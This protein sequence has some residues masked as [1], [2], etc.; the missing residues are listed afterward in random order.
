MS[1]DCTDCPY[2]LR[3]RVTRV[4]STDSDNL[5]SGSSNFDTVSSDSEAYTSLSELFRQEV[6]SLT[7][8]SDTINMAIAMTPEQLQALIEGIKGALTPQVVQPVAAT[9]SENLQPL[10]GNF[11][12]CHSRFSGAKSEDIDAFIDAITV[13][14]N[15]INVSDENALKGLPML[16][17][18]LAATWWQGVKTTI[19]DWEEAL[20]S[21]RRAF[22]KSKPAHKIFR[23]LFSKPQ[24]EKE[25]TDI[26]VSSARALL[27]RL[28][29]VPKL[30]ETH[31]LDMIYGLLSS[32]IRHRVSRDE[33]TSF[34][35]LIQRARSIE[36]NF[37]EANAEVT[38]KPAHN[39]TT[40]PQ[41]KLRP[42]CDFCRNFGH[43]QDECRKFVRTKQAS[44]SSTARGGSAEVGDEYTANSDNEKQ[45]KC[46]GCG[47]PGFIRS[48]CPKCSKTQKRS[49]TTEPNSSLSASLV[50]LLFMDSQLTS[51][52][53][54]SRPMLKIQV[55]GLT[56]LAHLDTGA[57]YNIAGNRLIQQVFYQNHPYT[58][59]SYN[60]ILADGVKRE[61]NA[62]KFTT[63][64]TLQ[65][66]SFETQFIGVPAHIHSKTLLG[67]EFITSAGLALDFSRNCWSFRDSPESM[68]EFELEPPHQAPKLT[69]V[70]SAIHL[71][72][73][74]ATS[75]TDLDRKRLNA[76]LDQ[77]SDLFAESGP[78]TTQ[79][80][81]TIKLTDDKPVAVPPYRLPPAK[82]ALLKEELEKLITQDIIEECDSP[83]AAPVVMVPKKD[84]GIRICIDYRQLN[85][86]TVPD[87]YPLPRIDDLLHSTK[88]AKIFTT[89]DL[90]SGYYQVPV[91]TEDRDKTAFITPFGIYRFKRLPF[92]LRNAP[93]T[94][95]RMID[96][97]K[98]G[99]PGVSMLAYLDDLIVYSDTYDDHI[100]DLNKVFKRLR[101]FRL[102]INRS[103][104]TF[105]GT[106]VKYLGHIINAE[107]IQPDSDKVAAI[108]KM[109]EPKNVKEL[110]SFVQT[111]SWFRRFIPN[112]ANVA[113][114]LTNLTKKD[115]PWIWEEE[116]ASSFS[117]LKKML[118]SPPILQQADPDGTYI[119][120]TDAS[121]YALGACLLQGESP[122]TERPVEYASRL[123]TEAERNYSTIEREALAVVWSINKFRGYLD[124]AKVVVRSDHQPLRWLLTLKSPTGR[125]A[126]WALA[127][128][129]FNLTIEYTPG[130]QNAVA[131]ALSRP[132]QNEPTVDVRSVTI[133]DLPTKT[134][135]EIREAQVADPDL[136]PILES[137]QNPGSM[138]C[139]R[140]S[141]RGYLTMNGILYRYSPEQEGEDAQLVVPKSCIPDILHHYHDSEYAGHYGIER[142]IQRIAA[143]YYWTG[144]R[145]QITDHVKKCLECQRFKVSNL[146][147]AG[148]MQT[149]IQNQRFEVL[150]VD[151]FGPLPET[152]TGERWVF[153]VED[154]A[155]RWVELFALKSATAEACARCLIDEVILR[156]GTP[157]RVISD[158][159][160]QFVSAIM[161][162]VAHCLG[163]KQSLT[164]LYHPEANP[165]ERKNR[166]LK[167]QLAIF[168]KDNHPSW[169][170]K[171][172][173]IRYA[174][175]SARN[176]A[177]GFTA[178]YLCFGREMRSPCE[179][180]HDL[181]SIVEKETFVPQ[182]TPYL[183]TLAETL[184]S[185]REKHEL[186]Q[187]QNKTHVDKHR[188]MGPVYKPGD[189]V[190]VNLHA[191]S[192]SSQSYT[193]KFA[194]LRD[195]PYVVLKEVSPTTYS[196][197]AAYGSKEPVGTYHSSMLTPYRTG[198]QNDENPVRP[199]R[200]RGRPRKDPQPQADPENG[201]RTNSHHRETPES[202]LRDTHHELDLSR[203]RKLDPKGEYV[204]RSGRHLAPP[205]RYRY[206]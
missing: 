124:G 38:S 161:Q 56:G 128:Q 189:K 20:K 36:E 206:N 116:Q 50:E 75:L 204:T 126:R 186:R 163:F 7:E 19:T 21:L 26:F 201:A 158:N 66:R 98:A 57:R 40:T 35:E 187:N 9:S 30:H 147:P 127:L 11:A 170:D 41:T 49:G 172:P 167:V 111:C 132:Y 179:V 18:G 102:R 64:V 74:E 60:M 2:N 202:R 37:S 169:K 53:D 149:P 120:R 8:D 135:A 97:M 164:P 5:D 24:E 196:I 140:W 110:L 104:C 33:I 141:E 146:K 92:G 152:P 91:R 67:I 81:H 157:R 154:V 70:M 143:N 182:I 153:I 3:S 191:L 31:Q 99:L 178:A 181:R 45:V 44:S 14:K 115:T 23:E 22:G 55:L 62:I 118:I 43:L 88:Q 101:Q 58:G 131:D 46:F 78:P 159:G 197:A 171:L 68:V 165:V 122:E 121:A 65:G 4:E 71:H 27:S 47:N 183:R 155:T 125:L 176:E 51:K 79:A 94:F 194:P 108:Q 90:K 180:Q 105:A 184:I 119:L 173:S 42:R 32:R 85:A 203:G 137:F 12:K 17:D 13:Y 117:T 95:Q 87:R 73:T 52:P 48:R 199:L 205:S 76:L 96:H 177:T 34:D 93:S 185:V 77:N 162:L 86:K 156:Y 190:L 25:P 109:R 129:S 59:T 61:V 134:S 175:N 72:E 39:K 100:E 54:L 130:R 174:M 136:R 200:S 166:D 138:E 139:T 83:Y 10:P 133:I 188:R 123:L 15:C 112:F 168:T 114:P 16:L 6:D 107:G 195:G 113:R 82:Q 193:S 69:E 148:L 150:S 80:E 198:G 89:L 1:N 151:L 103:K 106:E 160:T 63:T 84:S 28:P 142:T 145:R 192:K 144:M 29:E